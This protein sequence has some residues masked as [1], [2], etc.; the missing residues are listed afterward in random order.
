MRRIGLAVV[1]ALPLFLAPL[2]SGAQQADAA[3]RIG[4]LALNFPPNASFLQGLLEL[5]WVEGQNLRIES[6]SAGGDPARLPDLA[7]ELLRLRVEIIVA[8]DSAAIGPALQVTK[9][10]PIVM[11]VSGDPVMRGF[12]A[13]LGHP[14]G[15][16]TGLANL[17]PELVGKRLELL[18][19]L[20]PRL[21]RVA[22]LGEPNH[23]DWGPLDVAT[24]TVGV[25]LQALKVGNREGF[26][27]AFQLATSKRA[28]G[29]VVLPS[30]LTNTY[31][32]TLVGLAAIELV[33]NMKTAKA[34]GITIPQS[35][36]LR[37]DRVIEIE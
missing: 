23:G 11:T 30:P 6:R 33:I 2:A 13:S 7:N 24:A 26:E 22:V 20:V 1:L 8:G 16:V 28:E 3:R 29:L 31:M 5:G 9:T 18:R 25:Q 12:V 36:L 14:G 4:W 37:A 10:L 17:S 15:N 27:G 19:E 35:V 32:R 21:K 34:L